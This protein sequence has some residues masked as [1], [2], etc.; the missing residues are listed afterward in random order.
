M[1]GPNGCACVCA[2]VCVCV[3]VR[4]AK[5]LKMVGKMCRENCV[6]ET[7]ARKTLVVPATIVLVGSL[8][9]REGGG[10]EEVCGVCRT[11]D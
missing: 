8:G 5:S 3:R 2:K 9:M 4:S 10:K 11:R 7:S 1:G 6:R